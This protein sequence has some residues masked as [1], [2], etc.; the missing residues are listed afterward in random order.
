M[1]QITRAKSLK[2][3]KQILK[4]EYGY[5]DYDISITF[6][7]N[8]LMSMVDSLYS[9]DIS[10]QLNIDIE[11]I[12]LTKDGAS[13]MHIVIEHIK[14][15]VIVDRHFMRYHH[16][17]DGNIF[18]IG[19]EVIFDGKRYVIVFSDD[20]LVYIT[21]NSKF[22]GVAHEEIKIINE[23]ITFDKVKELFEIV[24]DLILDKIDVISYVEIFAHIY[25]IELASM[26]TDLRADIKERVMK[27]LKPYMDERNLCL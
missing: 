3:A 5:S 15:G 1:N 11:S 13:K 7:D 6:D 26:I 20:R 19:R 24:Y 18:F 10:R 27:R 17:I 25:D 16:V 22:M 4:E 9:R 8:T 23:K 12:G 14:R 2:E 21:D